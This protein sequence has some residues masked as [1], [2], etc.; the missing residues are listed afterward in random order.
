MAAELDT[1]GALAGELGQPERL[2]TALEHMFQLGCRLERLITYACC[3][4]DEDNSNPTY[5][6]LSDMDDAMP[7]T[8]SS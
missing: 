1:L 8:S 3:R 4:R 2:L 5:Q 6:R 7:C